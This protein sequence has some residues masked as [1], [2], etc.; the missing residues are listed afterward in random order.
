MCRVV[1]CL[2]QIKERYIGDRERGSENV[3]DCS[4][5]E[6][7]KTLFYISKYASFVFVCREEVTCKSFILALG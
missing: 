2:K 3:Y 5:Y 4:S 7:R 1:A 6:S